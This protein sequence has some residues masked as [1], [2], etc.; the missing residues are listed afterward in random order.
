[1]LLW[2]H[3]AIGPECSILTNSFLV[4]RAF[5]EARAKLQA[6]VCSISPLEMMEMISAHLLMSVNC[7]PH[8]SSRL[9]IVDNSQQRGSCKPLSARSRLD[10]K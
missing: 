8:L 4:E 2:I 3:A 7:C 1:M 10:P 5:A 6:T 9:I